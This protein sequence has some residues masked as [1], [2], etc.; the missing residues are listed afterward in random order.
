MTSEE[1]GQY[2]DDFELGAD[3]MPGESLTEYIER[4]RREFESKA[5]GG[6]IGIEVLFGPKVPAAPSQLVEES[7]IVLGY[8]GDAAAKS[9]GAKSQGRVGGSD[10]GESS[11]RSDPR[12]DGPDRSKI[13]QEQNINQ[14]KNQLG[15]K[16]PNL[17][18]KTFNAY[19][20]LPIGVK[21]AIN[22]VAP[23]DL[24][25]LFNVGN[26]INTGINQIKN[27]D[28]TEEDVTLG[29]ENLRTDLTKAQK[30]ALGKQKMGYDMGLF[31]I[32][33]VRENIKP[34]GDPDKPATNEE[35]K[36]FFQ[37]KDGGRVGLFMGGPALEGQALSIY[38]SMNA[39]GFTDQ[40]IADALSA[41]GLYTPSG[42]TQPE[43]VTGIIN[44]QINQSGD[45]KP[46]IRPFRE[47]PRVESAFEA[48]Q[49]NEGLKAL[50]I[51]DPFANEATLA[52]AYY[53]DMPN[54]DLG[55]G[56]QTFMGKVKSKMDSIV[57]LSPT[58]NFFRG[59][60][61]GI[62]NM[63]PVN[64]R[65]IAEN[66]AGNMGIAVD[67][68]GRVVNTGDYNDPNNVM[69]GYNL[70][71]MTDETFDKRID[72]ISETLSNKYGL[73]VNEI[74]GILEGTLTDA[75]LNAINAKAIMPGTTQTTNLIKQLRS[76]NIMKDQ[77]KFI[78]ETARKE[79]ER[80]ELERQRAATR[81]ADRRAGA[82]DDRVRLDPGGGGTFK[83][84]TAA[85]ERQG[86]QVAGPGFGRGAYFAEGGLAS[87]FVEKR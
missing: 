23:V 12:D 57:G 22:T 56:K 2:I 50:G 54:V 25:K 44:Q 52:G 36:E 74:Q 80:K 32:D 6:S 41:R 39:Y 65:A 69:A 43:Q 59:I 37:A 61:Q 16:D 29:I 67:D 60:E 19:N 81:E 5:D 7:E 85:K 42:A 28:I 55:P 79:A 10:V 64:Q 3:V 40:E 14:L 83:E 78:Q 4:R 84:Q 8:R 63:L 82:F 1:Y 46:T 48:Y 86:V 27:P 73:G 47:D 35:I 72:N 71:Q 77:N 24:M 45:D 30:K 18:Q 9:S 51:K 53:G 62:A 15:I 11:T 17:I 38:N 49:R 33:D 26:V 13:T 20:R 75:E 87:M 21:G 76:I 70:N 58:L 66:V 34:L 31:T 68:I